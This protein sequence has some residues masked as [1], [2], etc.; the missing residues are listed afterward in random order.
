VTFLEGTQL[1]FSMLRSERSSLTKL[2]N[3]TVPKLC[4]NCAKTLCNCVIGGYFERE[5]DSPKLLKTLKKPSEGR[6]LWNG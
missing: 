2:G 4:Q 5:A 6:D 1:L 3:R